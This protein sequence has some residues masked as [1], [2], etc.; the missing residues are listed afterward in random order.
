MADEGMNILFVPFWQT[1]KT[2]IQGKTLRASKT[3]KTN[4]MLPL[5]VV[6]VILKSK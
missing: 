6:W 3:M 1:P 4:V 5:Q 2:D